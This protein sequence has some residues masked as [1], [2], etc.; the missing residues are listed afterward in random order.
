MS[1]LELKVA[2]DVVWLAVAAFM[3]VSSVFTDGIRIPVIARAFLAGM[4][5]AAGVALIVSGRLELERSHTTWHPSGPG[6]T[7]SLVTTG[8]FRYSRNPIYLGMW[9]V[10]IAWAVVLTSPLALAVSVMFVLYLTRLQIVPEE[11]A[12]SALLGDQY[13]QYAS[14]VRRWL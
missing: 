6:R 14:R 3:W 7:T 4:F 12:L 2:P 9:F 1:A 13:R 5:L 11:R 10:L 8:V